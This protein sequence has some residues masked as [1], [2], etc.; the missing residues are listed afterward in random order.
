MVRYYPGHTGGDS[1]VTI[2]DA[3]VVFC[4]DLFWKKTLPNLID[5]TTDKWAATDAKLA[6]ESP[7][8]R[9]VPGHGDVGNAA[10]VQEFA[11]YLNDLRAMMAQPVKDG[12]MGDALINADNAR[13][14]AEVR[15]LEF[16]RLLCET[17]YFRHGERTARRQTTP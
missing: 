14:K 12:L 9:F 6:E 15:Q 3:Q 1:V 13:P 2:P 8:A 7:K 16:L 17:Q 4:G 11:G 5:G 10:D